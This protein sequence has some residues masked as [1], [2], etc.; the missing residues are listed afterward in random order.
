MDLPLE[1][2]TEF[3]RPLVNGWIAKIEAAD[4]Y[5]QRWKEVA[6]ECVMFYARSAAAMTNPS[7]GSKFFKGSSK[8][9]F[10]ISINK[11]FELV[12][13]YGP[14]LIWD[15]PHR[16]VEPKTLL[17]LSPEVFGDPNDQ[18]AQMLFQQ[19]Q[20]ELAQM[21]AQDKALASLL[22]TWLNYT[23]VEGNLSSQSEMAV[24]DALVKGRGCMWVKPYS[25]PS[26]QRTLTGAF[27]DPPENL[28]VDPDFDTMEDA[29]WIARKCVHP[30]WEVERKYGLEPGSLKGKASLES[31]WTRSERVGDPNA[32]NRRSAGESN[33]LIEYYEIWSKC[34]VGVRMTGMETVVKDHFDD[35]VGDYAYLVVSRSIP[36]PLNCPTEA[37][38]KGATDE[39]VKKRF[40][41][42]IPCWADNKW[43]VELLDFYR[44]TD[45]SWPIAPLAPAMGELKFINVMMGHLC[46]RIWTSSRDFIAVAESAMADL[47]KV[48][49][50]GEDQ[51]I[52]PIKDFQGGIDKMIAFLQQPQTNLDVWRILEAVSESFDK[53][54]GL[55]EFHYAQNPDGA[56]SRSAEDSRNKAS[57]A[58]I[59]PQYMQKK[60]VEWQSN[61]AGAE[62]FCARWFV[63][64]DDVQRLLGG[65]G[66]YLWEN[67]VMSS[68]VEDVVR[69][70][71][72]SV[73]ASSIRRPNKERDAQ[74][75]QS[76]MQSPFLQ[77]MGE[78]AA[79]TGNFDPLNKM[80]H[81]FGDAIEL[82]LSDI[83]L[84]APETNP[85]AEAAAQEQQMEQQRLE[86]EMQLKQMD[87][88]A[89]QQA[90]EMDAAKAQADIALKQ[91]QMQMDAQAK[92]LELEFDA[93]RHEQ[94][95]QQDQQRHTLD[96]Q[97]S[98][99]MGVQK[100]QQSQVEGQAKV[101][102]QKAIGEQKVAQ[103]K[104]MAQQKPKPAAKKKPTK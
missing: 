36:Y 40:E 50:E 101:E 33:D 20:M 3:L 93:K 1:L 42:P 94:E 102:Q 44:D 103:A 76:I 35:V 65:V 71:H 31:N 38:R 82:N 2:Q 83:Q 96:M 73:S 25:P 64:G 37:L 95:I 4:R 22:Q 88:Q 16:R 5:R 79:A 99:L 66:R 80:L 59:R 60:V 46:N 6:D 14:S 72:Y 77:I 26:S 30:V 86:G 78:Y 21:A 10:K 17:E 75:M 18:M 56:Q 74:N 97:Q 15:I 28:Y 104:K 55:T 87:M 32:A 58:G 24:I 68:D 90:M 61:I 62:A 63:T 49:E 98:A 52:I 57:A 12:A 9:K 89:K 85:A 67:T 84:E 54:T 69:Q 48:L 100:I 13:I 8:S 39:D 81:R 53:R 45:H 43:P 27:R 70:M 91:Q 47:K 41:W 7:L 11:A 23:A 34:G 19:S 92:M 51:T 29:K